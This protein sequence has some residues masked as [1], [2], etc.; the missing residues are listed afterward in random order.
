MHYVEFNERD[1]AFKSRISFFIPRIS[2]LNSRLWDRWTKPII[3]PSSLPVNPKHPTPVKTQDSFTSFPVIH[4]G[5]SS[6]ISVRGPEFF[7]SFSI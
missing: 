3:H 4:S 1:A 7:I 5:T 6:N 2:S